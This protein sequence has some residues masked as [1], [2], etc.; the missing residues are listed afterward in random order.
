LDAIWRL[1]G[2]TT[3]AELDAGQLDIARRGLRA[4]MAGRSVLGIARELVSI[5]GEGLRRIAEAGETD[6]DERNFL[7]PLHVQIERG[8]SPGEEIAERW[9]GEWGRSRARLIEATRY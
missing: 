9:R 7:D 3:M 2:D 6:Q 8:I 5:S 1:L 4:E